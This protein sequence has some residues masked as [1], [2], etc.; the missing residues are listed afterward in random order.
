MVRGALP[1]LPPPARPSEVL[2]GI[3]I[4]AVATGGL[5]RSVASRTSPSQLT[6]AVPSVHVQR[7]PAVAVAQ[8]GASLCEKHK[9]KQEWRQL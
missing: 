8:A 1:P 2:T 5:H 6:H 9:I 4:L 7:T 3:V